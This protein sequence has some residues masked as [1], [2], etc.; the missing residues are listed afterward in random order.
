MICRFGLGYTWIELVDLV[1]VIL[2]F[3]LARGD[4]GVSDFD[5]CF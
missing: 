1:V 2:G 5:A 4:F 3:A